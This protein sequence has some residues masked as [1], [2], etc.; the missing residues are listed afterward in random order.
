MTCTFTNARRG[1]LT[2]TKTVTDGPTR[3]AVDTYQVTYQI[4][5]GSQSYVDEVY[6]LVDEVLFGDGITVVSATATGPAG[7]SLEAGWNGTTSTLL[8]D[9]ATIAAL[10]TQQF[11]IVATGMVDLMSTVDSRD[12][13]LTTDE[14]GTGFLNDAT[15]TWLDGSASDEA[16]EQTPDPDV[17]DLVIV[18]TAGVATTGPDGAF[19]WV[20][21][22][23]N[24]GPAVAVNVLIGDLVPNQVTV[25][26]VASSQFACTHTANDVACT[27]ASMAV[28]ETGRVT[29]SVVV[30]AAA[31]SG[32]VTNVGTVESDTPDPDLT[33]N[34]D[35][36]T[37]D[38]VR[39]LAP[40][41]TTAILPA[42][43]SGSTNTLVTMGAWLSLAGAGAL[44]LAVRRRAGVL[45][46][47]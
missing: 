7:V 47:G 33:N 40:T 11:T 27:K 41:T 21:D 20:L 10:D 8:V 19:D 18:K 29:I 26:A 4:V 37:V 25:T 3:I 17:A 39:Q 13:V 9:D 44:L 16:C 30:P 24:D 22:I 38:I 23:T 28:G 5:V 35:D 2:I 6:D 43:G 36:A 32:S 15:V 12:C 42:T 45:E 34:S 31:V 1:P 46:T 14:S